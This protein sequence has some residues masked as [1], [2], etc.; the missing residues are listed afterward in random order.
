[1]I[2]VKNIKFALSGSYYEF[3]G[4]LVGDV[5]NCCELL[6]EVVT[7]DAEFGFE[8]IW[9]VGPAGMKDAGVVGG[10]FFAEAFVFFENDDGFMRMGL[11]EV[12]GGGETDD[13]AADE[14]DVDLFHLGGFYECGFKKVVEEKEDSI[15]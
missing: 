8:R 7:F 15:E 6:D 3:A 2:K 11:C 10:L 4:F 14:G 5:M 12:V 1:M 13:A 9:C